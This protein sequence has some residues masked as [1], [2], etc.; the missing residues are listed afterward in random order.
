MMQTNYDAEN[1]GGDPLWVSKATTTD[2]KFSREYVDEI[3]DTSD[4]G[5]EMFLFSPNRPADYAYSESHIQLMADT[6]GSYQAARGIPNGL[7]QREASKL[8]MEIFDGKVATLKKDGK[9]P[10]PT[11]LE[12][13]IELTSRLQALTKAVY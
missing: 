4:T 9:K 1:A 12:M 3:T 13:Q 6:I 8:Y 7:A 5:G 2:Q 10:A 11:V